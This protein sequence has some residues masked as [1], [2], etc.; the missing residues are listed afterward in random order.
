METT[1]NLQRRSILLLPTLIAA[2]MAMQVFIYLQ[3]KDSLI[4]TA[5]KSLQEA[6]DVAAQLISA[7]AAYDAQQLGSMYGR[8]ATLSQVQDAFSQL[9]EL[10]GSS[11]SIVI[12]YRKPSGEVRWLPPDLPKSLERKLTSHWGGSDQGR[13]SQAFLWPGRGLRR[14][15]W[16]RVEKLQL[17]TLV[18][19]SHQ[20]LVRPVQRLLLTSLL[21]TAGLGVLL[22]L[23]FQHAERR[24]AITR[25]RD[26]QRLR[27]LIEQFPDGIAIVN[28]QGQLVECNT[29]C[30][31]LLDVQLD[32]LIGKPL[33]ELLDPL[34]LE[35]RA[36]LRRAYVDIRRGR[37]HH[38]LWFV[39][40]PVHEAKREFDV[41]AV[42]MPG[43][44]C[45]IQVVLAFR[46]LSPGLA[47]AR[48][49]EIARSLLDK[50]RYQH[51]KD[52][53]SLAL[54]ELASAIAHELNQ[55]LTAFTG[56]AEAGMV[57]LRSCKNLPE[58]A[59]LRIEQACKQAHRAA[60]VLGGIRRML[61][62]QRRPFTEVRLAETLRHASDL[63]RAA[64]Q[65]DDPKIEF[66]FAPDLPPIMTDQGQLEQVLVN[67][68]HNALDASRTARTQEPIRVRVAENSGGIRIEVKDC[69]PGIP[70]DQLDRIFMP[71]FT[72][73]SRGAGLGLPLSRQ[74]IERL[75]GRLVACAAPDRGA[76][77]CIHLPRSPN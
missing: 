49:L 38:G 66:D 76:C 63:I 37:A 39:R 9:P 59:L 26:E 3:M 61:A 6:A 20:E 67:L 46:G 24:A 33:L 23:F 43:L 17:L 48:E 32:Q 73:R 5:D 62:H 77:F 75:G 1:W 42:Q 12:Q 25:K 65:P 44:E 10:Y 45:Q 27:L 21:V 4:R 41:T 51:E 58:Q 69:G 36:R 40:H 14:F 52:G 47:E 34:D 53:R 13:D 19:T 8:S 11:L 74:I 57:A 60:E 70:I 54:S 28:L 64:I 71:F 72:T 16:A 15:A 7:V 35:Q 18:H 29:R 22:V 30:C 56:Y 31:A 50:A 2:C 55:P 68:L